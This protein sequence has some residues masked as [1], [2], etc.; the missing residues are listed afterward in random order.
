MHT[1]KL[2]YGWWE[3]KRGKDPVL[4]TTYKHPN[5]YVMQSDELCEYM[6][7]LEELKIVVTAEYE[8]ARLTHRVLYKGR[9]L[10]WEGDPTL[11]TT[12]HVLEFFVK[13]MKCKL[14]LMKLLLYVARAR[15]GVP[16]V[17][18]ETFTEG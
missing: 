7:A 13:F 2:E 11:F 8:R 18:N 5:N 4:P 15:K 9:L 16:Q 10:S 6:F 17:E 3:R 12:A 1:D 14:R